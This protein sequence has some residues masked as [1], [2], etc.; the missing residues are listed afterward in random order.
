MEP[1]TGLTILGTAIG[2][3]KLVEKLLGPT[4]DYIG[5]GLKNWTEKRVNN[6]SRIFNNA[7][8][9][10]G[11]EIEK[12]GS[13]PPKVLK[14][15]LDNGS[16]CDDELTAE[17]F[18][19][20]LASSR[21]GVSRDDRGASYI[22]LLSRLSTYQ[23]RAHYCFYHIFKETFDGMR[24]KAGSIT[25]KEGRKDFEVA[26]PVSIYE[27]FMGFIDGENGDLIVAHIIS[28][29][30]KELLIDEWFG[31]GTGRFVRHRLGPTE[32]YHELVL[33][34]IPTLSGIELFLWAH[35]KPN[36]MFTEFFDPSN[37]F[38]LDES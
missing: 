16:F 30:Y 5:S 2:S 27:T 23:I 18:G 31:I 7:A 36:L 13:V 32:F 19:G 37:Q 38:P 4:A 35:G 6:V 22:T 20:V 11:D 34:V 17:Y 25:H 28:G 3:A 1:G 10:L 9:K 29:L 12:E 33:S 26:I 24:S 14:G 8:K 21:T 15:I